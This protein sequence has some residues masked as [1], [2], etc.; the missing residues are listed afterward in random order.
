MRWEEKRKHK[1]A[2]IKFPV[3][4]RSKSFWQYIEARDISAGGL[5]VV[6][7]KVEPPKTRIEIMFEFGE[8][9]K[10]FIH[11]EGVVAWSRP[12]PVQDETGDVQPAGMGIEFT[13]ITPLA[14]KDFIDRV[15]KRI[16]EGKG[17]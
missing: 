7:D 14:A 4:Y 2:Y 10:R 13:K 15:I 5:F 3:E 1:R 11:A 12:K 8:G 17:A 16:E 9:E 6:T